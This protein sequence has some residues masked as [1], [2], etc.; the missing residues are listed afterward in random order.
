LPFEIT[1]KT[2]HISWEKPCADCTGSVTGVS[3]S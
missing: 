1:G 2:G 3:G